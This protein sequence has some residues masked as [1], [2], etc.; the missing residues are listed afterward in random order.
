MPLPSPP[1]P[2]IQLEVV[3]VD[4]PNS[5][6]A[7]PIGFAEMPPVAVAPVQIKLIGGGL[8]F[9]SRLT[10]PVSE[11]PEYKFPAD[12]STPAELKIGMLENDGAL[13][14]AATVA[15]D[16]MAFH[17]TPAGSEESSAAELAASALYVLTE[18]LLAPVSCEVA[19]MIW[20]WE[21]GWRLVGSMTD[22]RSGAEDP[23]TIAAATAKRT[24]EFD[25]RPINM[26]RL[27][28]NATIQ[29]NGP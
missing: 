9:S 3:K 29:R 8:P 20:Y 5:G 14:L 10:L 17:V 23:A 6:S 16:T 1:K 28:R 21:P 26:C 15:V 4:S 25:N 19:K 27:P 13:A 24:S 18:P 7:E 2:V 11:P 22:A 12:T